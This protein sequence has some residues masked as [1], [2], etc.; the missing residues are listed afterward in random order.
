MQSMTRSAIP[1]STALTLHPSTTQEHT[2]MPNHR[3]RHIIALHLMLFVI[4]AAVPHATQAQ[5]F[6]VEGD[7]TVD[8]RIGI[9]NDAPQ[10]A[11]DIG[12]AGFSIHDGGHKVIGFGF[13]PARLGDLDPNRYGAEVRLDP[14]A[15]RLRLGVAGTPSGMPVTHMTIRHTGSVGIGTMTPDTKLH[16]SN[17]D[18]KLDNDRSLFLGSDHNHDARI[19]HNDAQNALDIISGWG[20]TGHELRL[21][22]GTAGSWQPYVHIKANGRVGIN[23]S[24]PQDLFHV[25]ANRMI[26]EG[27]SPGNASTPSIDFRQ[28]GVAAKWVIGKRGSNWGT[29]PNWLFLAHY[30]G[31]QWHHTVDYMTDGNVQFANNVGIGRSPAAR[32]DVQ[33]DAIVRGGATIEG[34]LIA[35]HVP[36]Q[37]D[38]SMGPFNTP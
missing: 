1:I 35:Q 24:N 15:G 37:G 29:K 33:G 34:P 8:G 2:I 13:S 32:L 3:S 19:R 6:E 16:V 4:P 23:E 22:V 31:T 18:M 5:G 21:G 25:T 7:L 28:K 12:T 27:T 10:N 30:D 36:E 9:G 11:I 20:E 38:L 17:G 26:L 14:D